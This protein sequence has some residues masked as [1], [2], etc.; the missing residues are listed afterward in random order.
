MNSKKSPIRTNS[1]SS[2]DTSIRNLEDY[3]PGATRS[4]VFTALRKAAKPI[5]TKT[6]KRAE[7]LAPASS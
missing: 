2:H 5:I 4:E 6:R 1:K 7:P 3:E